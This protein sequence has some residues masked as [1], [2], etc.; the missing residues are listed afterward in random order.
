MMK[1]GIALSLSALAATQLMGAD[2]SVGGK[3]AGTLDVQFKAMTVLS[4]KKNGFAPSNGTGV[5]AKLKYESADVLTEGL[6][7][8]IGTYVN[9]DA[10]LT[11]W[12]ENNPAGGYNKA[13][14]GM[15]VSPD[16]DAVG[17]VGELYVSYKNKYVNAKFGRQTLETPLTQIQ[18][19][20]MP[21][22]YEA[23]M[24]STEAIDGLKLTAGQ[25]TRMSYGSRGGA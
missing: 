18:I 7:F 11:K 15:A 14:F 1:K 17:H 25:I 24:L 9:G 23:Y 2:V 4:D 20:L 8:G 10:G 5:L 21:N 12:D 6:K 3:D 22:F 19:S 16:G 13:A